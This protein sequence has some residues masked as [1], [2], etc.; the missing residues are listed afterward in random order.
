MRFF[1]FS[2]RWL[3]YYMIIFIHE[4][5]FHWKIPTCSKLAY[6]FCLVKQC[7]FVCRQLWHIFWSLR[8]TWE[9]SKSVL[10]NHISCPFSYWLIQ[11]LKHN[12]LNSY[13]SWEENVSCFW[14]DHEMWSSYFERKKKK[15]Q[16]SIITPTQ[17]LL[18]SRAFP[19][20]TAGKSQVF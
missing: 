4:H 10:T 11:K 3:K 9:S 8:N 6:Y 12:K 5:T 15:H 13:I 2:C 17:S 20:M 19:S 7:L 14:E 18:M 16:E 1:T